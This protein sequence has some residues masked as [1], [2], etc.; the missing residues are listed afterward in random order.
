MPARLHVF[1]ATWNLHGK[2]VDDDLA[3]LLTSST[4][5]PDVY[6]VGTQEAGR[7]IEASVLRPSKAKWQAKLEDALGEGYVCVGSQTLVAIHL[8]VFVR[9]PWLERVSSVQC[10]HVAT[11]QA[12]MLGNKGGV[13]IA[14]AIGA[15]SFVFVNA[16]FAAHQTKVHQR[17]ADFHRID[18]G[19]R[20]KP[21]ALASPT[22]PTAIGAPAS[23][24]SDGIHVESPQI[25]SYPPS[26]P[27][28]PRSSLEATQAPAV[29]APA[30]AVP[31]L[32][33]GQ[34]ASFDEASA[35]SSL[36]AGSVSERARAVS[37]AE[38]SV[39]GGGRA[40][41]SFDRVF[42]M[43][44]LNYRINGTRELIDALLAPPDERARS[45]P[46]WEGDE[47]HEKAMKAALLANDQLRAQMS[48]GRVFGGFVEGDIHFRPTY[49][50]DKKDR[51]A[52]DHSAKRRIPAYTDRILFSPPPTAWPAATPI[53]LPT[54]PG[55]CDGTGQVDG[56]IQLLR[57][58]A[59]S[60]YLC[61]DHKPVVAEFDVHYMATAA[62]EYSAAARW[63]RKP[64]HRLARTGSGHW[65]SGVVAHG[66]LQTTPRTGLSP[67]P[68]DR[69]R[70]GGSQTGPTPQQSSVCAVM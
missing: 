15:T 50:F 9:R 12:D 8:A 14:I 48:S 40:S 21:P 69:G 64:P 46:T 19:L 61:S 47:A 53:P 45:A 44:D 24:P 2:D 4:G 6:A 39:P 22:V 54:A 42:W 60:S 1:V 20:L 66:E 13:A 17:N 32:R 10:S 35:V 56:A 23:K 70:R 31:S 29:A 34:A 55:A 41:T 26:P 62:D 18:R 30:H 52:Y 33:A 59:V 38:D 63:R 65:A 28:S 36:A 67:R 68:A 7:T 58:D 51:N 25:P 27:A 5:A 37:L 57:Y 16:H 3:P 11:G 43:G 49:K